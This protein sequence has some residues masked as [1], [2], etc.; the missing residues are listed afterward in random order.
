MPPEFPKRGDI[1]E[2]PMRPEALYNGYRARFLEEIDMNTVTIRTKIFLYLIKHNVDLAILYRMKAELP[3]RLNNVV[4]VGAIDTIEKTR[5]LG[6]IMDIGISA[7]DLRIRVLNRISKTSL[8]DKY[9]VIQYL[10]L[11]TA[12]CCIHTMPTLHPVRHLTP[13][14]SYINFETYQDYIF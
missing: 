6:I 7:M 2:Y 13:H 12:L 4:G 9:Y 8:E 10:S 1:V 11:K 14:P 5:L 3:E